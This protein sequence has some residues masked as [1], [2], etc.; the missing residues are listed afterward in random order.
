MLCVWRAT[1]GGAASA[2]ASAVMTRPMICQMFQPH[3]VRF[4]TDRAAGAANAQRHAWKARRRRGW[5]RD[6]VDMAGVR[7]GAGDHVSM[8]RLSR[9][10]RGAD[11][12]GRP[13]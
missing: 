9:A 7:A 6:R 4:H 13:H 3:G 5:F 10:V 11:Q 8:R 1:K 2:I 12:V